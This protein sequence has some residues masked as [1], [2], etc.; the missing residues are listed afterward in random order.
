MTLLSMAV[1]DTLENQR[2]PMTEETL[3]S[4]G[5]TVN[6]A[7]HSL[8]VIDNASCQETKDLLKKYQAM[9]GFTLI[10]NE[11]NIGTARAINQALKFRKLGESAI[12]LDNDIKIHQRGW[13][14]LMEE[15][16]DREP[17]IGVLGLKRVDLLQTPNL[18]DGHWAQ[19]HLFMCKQEPG[20]R[21]IVCE[22][23]HDIMGTCIMMSG[24]LLDKINGLVQLKSGYGFD[25]NL[26]CVRSLKAGFINCFLPAIDI[27]HI[28]N[29][30]N[31]DYV[32]WKQKVAGEQMAEYN[33][34]KNEYM[35]GT[36]DIF[37][38]FE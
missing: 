5:N 2:T 17:I 12:K 21:W 33:T 1:F 6:F 10:T 23:A 30:G 14:D 36:R 8:Y 7:K 35:N 18:P 19:S 28:D 26:L 34:M 24:A 37:H 16:I 9:M 4:L 11:E 3:I 32:L 27:E 25:D 13:V 22:Q 15:A 20:Q 31:T 38:P 29:S